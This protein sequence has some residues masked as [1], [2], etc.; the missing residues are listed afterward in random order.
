MPKLKLYSSAGCPFCRKVTNYLDQR[1]IS[2][3]IEDPF[4][5]Y[6]KMYAFKDLTG[7]T[8]VP[9]L[10]IDD[11]IMHESDDIIAWFAANWKS[12]L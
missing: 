12:F 2:I 5:D 9:C 4:A 6:E 10:Q 8:Q 11:K 7:K 1:G 3:P